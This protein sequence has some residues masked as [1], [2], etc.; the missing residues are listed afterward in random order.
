MWS[1]DFYIPPC[2]VQLQKNLDFT[3]PAATQIS[4]KSIWISS[5]LISDFLHFTYKQIKRSSS[6]TTTEMKLTSTKNFLI[7]ICLLSLFNLQYQSH[8]QLET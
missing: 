1:R 7:E 2:S 8:L 5:I 4:Q 6:S 3:E